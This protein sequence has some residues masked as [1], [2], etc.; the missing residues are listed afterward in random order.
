MY[1]QRLLVKL[2]RDSNE[3]RQEREELNMKSLAQLRQLEQVDPM[4]G[5][6]YRDL[7]ELLLSS[8][9]STSGG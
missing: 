3:T 6:R 8:R 7:G 5:A 4:R 9:S 2:L 1:Y